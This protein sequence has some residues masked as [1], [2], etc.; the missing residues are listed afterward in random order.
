MAAPETGIDIGFDVKMDKPTGSVAF[1]GATIVTMNGDE[2]I[3]N[4][5]LV[6]ENNRIQA[7]GGA[8][9]S[10]P[11]GATILDASGKTIIPGLVDVHWHGAMAGGASQNE[12]IG[13]VT[14]LLEAAEGATTAAP[15][16]VAQAPA[17]PAATSRCS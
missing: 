14:V 3:S 2:I 9:T 16:P 4:G 7:I 15:A 5:V 10:I 6:E 8:D 1:S 12:L 11:A 17:A 13:K